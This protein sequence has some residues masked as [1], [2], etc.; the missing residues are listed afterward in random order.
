[1]ARVDAVACTANPKVLLHP[2]ASPAVVRSRDLVAIAVVDF[3]ERL[4]IECGR[5]PLEARQWV[6]AA[7]EVRDKVL[8]TG[9]EGVDAAKRAGNQ[10]VDRAKSAM[11]KLSIDI[12]QRTLR[13][14]HG[15]ERG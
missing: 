2:T 8:V 9:A 4:G 15:D 3:H 14:R 7:A 6:D 11:G 5:Q 12:T 10:A 1:M 13:R